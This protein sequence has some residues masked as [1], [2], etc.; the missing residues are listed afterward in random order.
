MENRTEAA[1]KERLERHSRIKW[2]MQEIQK[3]ES[4]D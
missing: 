1:N 2:D 4:K 3:K